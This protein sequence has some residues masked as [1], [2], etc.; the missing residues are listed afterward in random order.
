[1]HGDAIRFLC[2]HHGMGFVDAVTDLAQQV[3][4]PVPE[5]SSTAEE[6]AESA[7]RREQSASLTDVLARAADHYKLQLKSSPQRS[8]TS[9][10]RGPERRDRRALRARL[11]PEGLAHAGERLPALR[12]P[13][14]RSRRGS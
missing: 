1:V 10:G 5:D 13:A 14:A 7:R 12:R 4:M 6:R 11:G 3:G 8:N 2:E 9:R